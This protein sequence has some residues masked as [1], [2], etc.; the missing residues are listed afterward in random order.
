MILFKAST[1]F[2]YYFSFIYRMK[3]LSAIMILTLMLLFVV[4]KARAQFDV[5]FNQ[6]WDIH[7]YYNPA[8][9]G[10]TDK[11]NIYGTYSMQLTNFTRAPKTM[12]FGA[13]MPFTLFNKKQGV[14]AGFFN[15]AIGLFRNQRAW[16]Q[17]S[18]KL[19]LRNG[20]LGLGFQVG[21]INVS[22]DPKDLDMGSS[23]ESDPAFPSTKQSGTGLDIGIGGYYSNSKFYAGFSGQHLT[24]PLLEFSSSEN[25]ETSEIKIKPM[26][27]FT[28]G[29]NIQT[30]NPL[31][32]IQPS[33]MVQSDFNSTRLDLTGRMYYTYQEKRFS[34]GL[35]YS[36][37][38]SVTFILG[39]AIKAITIGYSYEMYTSQIGVGNGSHDLVVSYAMDINLFK[40]SKNKHKGIRIL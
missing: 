2:Y 26:L 8:W 27:Y 16:L 19:K 24:S 31:I 4:Q 40:K 37:S 35:G 14:G 1:I 32:S 33:F 28:S 15:D 29:Y 17:Y 21:L 9:A 11:L 6:Y 36:P 39:A 30:R 23:S 12:Y 10:Q 20:L 25:G 38:T 3:R 22:F 18:Y 13:D 34:F 7:G 5:H